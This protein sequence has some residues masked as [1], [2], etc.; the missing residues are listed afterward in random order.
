MLPLG[1]LRRRNFAMGNLETFVLYGGLGV[2][3]FLPVLFLQQVAG[4]DALEA[5]LA[6]LPVTVVLFALS[7]RAG[8]L[9][10][11]LGPRWFMGLGPLVGAAG[12]L[13]FQRVDADVDYA[14]DILPALLVFSLGLGAT[15]APLTTAVLADADEDNAGIASGLNNAVA[16]VG[17]LL[18][19]ALLGT[20]LAS[21]FRSVA[22]GDLGARPLSPA[23]REVVADA[24]RR[25]M[26]RAD[27]SALPPPERRPVAR[28]VEHASVR[29]FHLGMGLSAGLVGLGGLIGVV[30][31]V[32]PRPRARPRD[33]AA[34]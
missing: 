19:V 31:I 15:V 12:L 24:Q 6:M 7:R 20:V 11:R 26:A 33:P 30:G 5:G 29:A 1:L 16:R 25:T 32:N 28:A 13:L 10:D 27:V 21:A 23:A 3:I 17:S 8:A 22:H 2:T 14:T 9:A 34:R 4:Y 18:V